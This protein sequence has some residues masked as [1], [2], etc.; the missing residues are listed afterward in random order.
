MLA[1]HQVTQARPVGLRPWQRWSPA[2]QQAALQRLRRDSFHGG[3]AVLGVGVGRRRR[4]VDTRVPLDDD[5]WWAQPGN[6]VLSID[7]ASFRGTDWCITMALLAP[8]RRLLTILADDRIA[9]RDAW[10]AR[11]PA[12]VR[13]RIQGVGIAR[14]AAYRKAIQRGGPHTQVVRDPFHRVQDGT[15]RLDAGGASNRSRRAP[16]S[17]GGRS[18][19]AGSL[20]GLARPRRWPR[21]DTPI[22]R[23]GPCTA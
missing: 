7:E 12:D 16:P 17:A 13:A 15:H 14:T 6:L 4:L 3:A 23:E 9:T 5:T 20:C 1:C 2:A 18:S 11:I 22:P 10:F 8:E 21:S 19:K